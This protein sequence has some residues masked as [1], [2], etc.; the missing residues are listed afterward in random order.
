MLGHSVLGSNCE[1]DDK[2]IG[3]SCERAHVMLGYYNNT[4]A[5]QASFSEDG[6]LHTGDMGS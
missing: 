1:P 6:W 5:T 3:G 2:G 4:D